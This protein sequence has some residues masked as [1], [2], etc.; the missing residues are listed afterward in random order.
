[1][2]GIIDKKNPRKEPRIIVRVTNEV[3]EATNLLVGTGIGT[4]LAD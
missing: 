2:I 3:G 4:I 1:M